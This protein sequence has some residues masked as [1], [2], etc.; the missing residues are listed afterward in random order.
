M[1]SNDTDTKTEWRSAHLFNHAS[2][3]KMP[4]RSPMQS[5]PQQGRLRVA[6][7][8]FRPSS[9]ESALVVAWPRWSA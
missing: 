8:E 6:L 9:S 2:F 7:S 5:A 1:V 4:S 3:V